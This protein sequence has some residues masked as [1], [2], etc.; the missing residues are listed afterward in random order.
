MI[1]TEASL[2][3]VNTELS[4]PVTM[5]RFRPNVVVEGM[6]AFDEVSMSIHSVI[7]RKLIRL[8]LWSHFFPFLQDKWAAK[9]IKVGDV[10]FRFLKRCGRLV[11]HKIH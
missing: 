10:E 4:S 2:E 9:I 11:S 8:S 3:A 6:K 5:E 7:S 1:A